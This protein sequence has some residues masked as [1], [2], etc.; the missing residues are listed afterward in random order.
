MLGSAKPELMT[1]KWDYRLWDVWN[2]EQAAQTV[3]EGR[4]KPVQ[5][6]KG[7]R[8]TKERLKRV[9]RW[10]RNGQDDG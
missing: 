1:W 2:A 3:A 8:A 6:R 4:Q 5:M 7:V 10:M 9:S